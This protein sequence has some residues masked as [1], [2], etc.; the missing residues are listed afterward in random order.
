MTHRERLERR[1]ALRAE[2]AAKATSRAADRAAT[3]DSLAERFAGGQPILVGHHSEGKARRNQ[4]RMHANMSKSVAEATLAESHAVKAAHIEHVLAT[5]IFSDDLDAVAALQAR[6]DQRESKA[7]A[8]VALN[9]AWR[10]SKGDP[11]AFAALAGI[12]DC[13]AREITK[14][15]EGAYSWEKQPYPGYELALIRAAIRKDK[16]RQQAI[17]AKEVADAPK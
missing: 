15:I 16:Q 5:A 12:G 4:A 17:N 13:L 3:A 10:Q 6:I 8:M 2:W 1:A 9:K 7:A 11:V 14:R